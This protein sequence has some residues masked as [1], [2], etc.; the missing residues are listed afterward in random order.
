MYTFNTQMRPLT[1]SMSDVQ[2]G[3][4]HRNII[5]EEP[6]WRVPGGDSAVALSASKV[7]ATRWHASSGNAR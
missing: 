3:L 7:V 4:V 1:D 2:S 5:G 6:K